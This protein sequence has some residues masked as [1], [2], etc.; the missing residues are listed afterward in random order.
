LEVLLGQ[1]ERLADLVDRLTGVRRDVRDHR[2]SGLGD[3]LGRALGALATASSGLPRRRSDRLAWAP[4]ATLALRRC[5]S[6]AERFLHCFERGGAHELRQLVEKGV[7]AGADGCVE[8]HGRHAE[9]GSMRDWPLQVGDGIYGVAP[10]PPPC[11]R[12]GP[13][14]APLRDE[15]WGEHDREPDVVD[16]EAG[17]VVAPRRGAAGGRVAV[18]AAA[19]NDQWGRR[20]QMGASPRRAVE[21]C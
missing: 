6:G 4:R 20:S 8:R 5:S 9:D 18:P 19:P 3:V 14:S 11:R 17:V 1:P 10:L 15:S 12:L 16:R 21:R 13:R 7:D 2:R